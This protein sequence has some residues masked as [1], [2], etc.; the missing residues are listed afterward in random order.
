[1]QLEI[2]VDQIEAAFSE[3][4]ELRVANHTAVLDL[5]GHSFRELARND[6]LNTAGTAR[7]GSISA[8]PGAKVE[9]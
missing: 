5:P 7:D 2:A 6:V 8:G 4:K 3:W 1:M 9:C